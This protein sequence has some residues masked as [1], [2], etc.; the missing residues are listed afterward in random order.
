MA[1]A[2]TP[3]A[4]R[5]KNILEQWEH[6]IGEDAAYK[7][8]IK[9]ISTMYAQQPQETFTMLIFGTTGSG[10]STLINNFVGEKVAPVGESVQSET[11]SI[12][13]Y[14]ACVHGVKL[15]IY[16]TPGLQDSRG[17]EHDRQHIEEIKRLVRQQNHSL[18][19]FCF[20]ITQTRL[21]EN[22]ELLQQFNKL[23]IQWDKV[24][25]AF[26]FADRLRGDRKPLNK[27][28]QKWKTAISDVLVRKIGIPEETASK[29]QF[30]P[31]TD[32]PSPEQ[33]ENAHCKQWFADLWFAILEKLDPKYMC[34]FLKI[35]NKYLKKET[36]E[37]NEQQ[38]KTDA[39]C[40]LEVLVDEY[41][42]SITVR[43]KR[44]IIF[45]AHKLRILES[46]NNHPHSD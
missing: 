21:R 9:R 15:I 18:C 28:V 7:N 44:M 37:N 29:M 2:S 46:E 41:D 32:N 30:C 43:L 4:D 35:R 1:E 5:K 36:G 27:H 31:T 8:A 45:V 19:I 39:Q 22:P 38:H 26:T 24:V 10:K 16:D 25:T 33:R 20:D 34:D 3:T 12:G 11:D 17:T 6:D 40:T 13:K 42:R 14:E 23:G